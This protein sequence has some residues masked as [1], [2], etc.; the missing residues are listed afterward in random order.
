VSSLNLANFYADAIANNNLGSGQYLTDIGAGN[1][2][3]ANGAGL[4]TTNLLIS[5]L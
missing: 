4:S 5:G 3:W 2:I 1:E